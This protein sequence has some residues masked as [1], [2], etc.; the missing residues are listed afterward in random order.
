MAPNL[1]V[2]VKISV[3][4]CVHHVSNMQDKT[5]PAARDT[6]CIFNSIISKIDASSEGKSEELENVVWDGMLSKINL[7]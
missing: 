2:R 1:S 4:A 6:L 5:V 3:I 7:T